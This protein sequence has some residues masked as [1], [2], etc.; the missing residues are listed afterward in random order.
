MVVTVEKAAVN[1]EVVTFSLAII[2]I[3][4]LSKPNCFCRHINF[5]SAVIG[6]L[7]IY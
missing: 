5:V 3:N 2:L 7:E 4:M 6:L 1:F